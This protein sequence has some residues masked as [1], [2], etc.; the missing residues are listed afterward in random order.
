MSEFG[1]RMALG[2]RAPQIAGL[3]VRQAAILCAAGVPLG[4]GAFLAIY[5]YYGEALLRGRP[6]D[7]A[8]LCA[9]AVIAV[10][11]VLAGAVLPALRAARLDPLEVLRAE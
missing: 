1:V 2:A 11:A 3:V 9:G 5:R 4:V 8:A 7:F 10:A 6:T